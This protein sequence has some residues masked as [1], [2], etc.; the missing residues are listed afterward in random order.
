MGMHRTR[1]PKATEAIPGLAV[2]APVATNSAQ[3]FSISECGTAAFQTGVGFSSRFMDRSG[4]HSELAVRFQDV[5]GAA[6]ALAGT[7]TARP[8]RRACPKRPQGAEAQGAD[9]APGLR[10]FPFGW[11]GTGTH[12]HAGG[13]LMLCSCSLSPPSKEQVTQPE[14]R[15]LSRLWG[16]RAFVRARMKTPLLAASGLGPTVSGALDLAPRARQAGAVGRIKPLQV[17]RVS[18]EATQRSRQH[19]SRHGDQHP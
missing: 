8:R 9:A 19:H 11:R 15:Q 18:A 3:G 13:A 16:I 1:P 14:L 4:V 6:T 2:R 7:R 10:M 5:R 12:R 17:L